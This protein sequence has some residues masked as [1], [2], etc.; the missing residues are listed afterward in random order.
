MYY[1]LYIFVI[2]FILKIL[3][4]SFLVNGISQQ[5][6]ALRGAVA[7]VTGPD[8]S[9]RGGSHPLPLLL[10]GG[11]RT[12]GRGR[13]TISPLCELLQ[14]CLHTLTPS[15][16]PSRFPTHFAA[17]SSP[18]VQCEVYER[19][20]SAFE[21]QKLVGIARGKDGGGG[22]RHSGPDNAGGWGGRV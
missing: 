19:K 7:A 20:E 10:K 22:G 1:V 16:L 5:A 12:E 18:I 15:L 11:R 2:D 8:C 9:S 3:F 13:D 6:E 17:F 4:A 14:L 21:S